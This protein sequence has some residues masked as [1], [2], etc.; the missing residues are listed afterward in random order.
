VPVDA[1]R[2]RQIVRHVDAHPIAF[3]DFDRR[4]VDLFVVTPAMR[5]Q[6]FIGLSLRHELVPDFIDREVE[7]L[8]AID[9]FPRRG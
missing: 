1:R 3:D 6:R 7:D 8:H 5:A 9:E 4:A 2:R